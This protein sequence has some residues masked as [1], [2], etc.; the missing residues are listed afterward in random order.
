MKK[1]MIAAAI[2]CAA[3]FAQ[4]ATYNWSGSSGWISADGDDGLAGKQVYMFNVSDIAKSALLEDLTMDNINKYA[5]ELSSGGNYAT[6]GI[7][8]NFNVTGTAGG[9]VT[10]LGKGGTANA[11]ALILDAG[12]DGKT[13]AYAID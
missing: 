1:L 2:V 3:A 9:Y 5:L 6:T 4:A 12:T 10:D 13:Y 11:F 7:D 8:G